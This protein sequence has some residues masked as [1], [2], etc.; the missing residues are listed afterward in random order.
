MVHPD[1][2]SDKSSAETDIEQAVRKISSRRDGNQAVLLY[3][4]QENTGSATTDA[5]KIVAGLGEIGRRTFNK[6]PIRRLF[7]TGGDTV[8]SLFDKLG[9]KALEIQKELEHGICQGKV[10]D[11]LVDGLEVITKAGSFGDSGTLIRFFKG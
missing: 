3:V 8:S 1:S 7:V 11:G 9:V 5:S 4:F 10:I 6:I 2:F